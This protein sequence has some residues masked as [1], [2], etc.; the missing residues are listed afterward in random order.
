MKKC[1]QYYIVRDYINEN[2]L[3]DFDKLTSNDIKY[4]IIFIPG[5]EKYLKKK[6]KTKI[7]IIDFKQKTLK[8]I[9]GWL[10]DEIDKCE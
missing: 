3:Y 7:S 5:L 1:V 2:K 10:L 4:F 6:L 8:F 9:N